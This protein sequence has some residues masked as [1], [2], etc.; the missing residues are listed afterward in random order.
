[1]IKISI[2]IKNSIIKDHK[3]NK[4]I[5]IKNK[6]NNNNFKIN[7]SKQKI[8]YRKKKLNTTALLTIQLYFSLISTKKMIRLL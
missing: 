7:K 1:M 6:I 3:K 2:S 5:I 4:K 8:K